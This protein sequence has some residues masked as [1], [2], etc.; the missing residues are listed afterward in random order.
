MAST[1]VTTS[2]AR[3]LSDEDPIMKELG[4]DEPAPLGPA[5]PEVT[6]ENITAAEE[7][8]HLSS[9]DELNLSLPNPARRKNHM[10]M[11]RRN[12]ATA[13]KDF[14]SVFGDDDSVLTDFGR[15]KAA[16][17][18]TFAGLARDAKRHIDELCV[19]NQQLTKKL[20]SQTT[21]INLGTTILNA[22]RAKHPQVLDDA[23][24]A[25]RAQ[26]ANAYPYGPPPTPVPN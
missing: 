7:P 8:L 19:E 26:P 21:R 5:P 14:V 2:Q 9:G 10:S 16:Q 25:M 17:L 15:S 11:L 13:M 3:I 1:P 4:L 18:A 6:N 20:K 12:E 24:A 22:I 23:I